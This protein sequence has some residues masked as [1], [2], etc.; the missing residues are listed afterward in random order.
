MAHIDLS[1]RQFGRLLVVSR[2]KESYRGKTRWLCKCDC[3]NEKVIVGQ[4]L[5]QGS[6]KTCGCY[7]KDVNNRKHGHALKTGNSPT[8]SSWQAMRGRCRDPNNKDF[9]NY[10]GRGIGICERWMEFKNF[11]EDMGEKPAAGYVLSRKDH[12]KGYEPGNAVWQTPSEN[13]LDV[14]NRIRSGSMKWVSRL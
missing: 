8:Y 10:G 13:S 14:W 7:L 9:R 2:D 3:G 4:S 5:L 11:L 12:D 1:G 6:S